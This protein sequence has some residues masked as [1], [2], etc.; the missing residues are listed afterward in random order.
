MKQWTLGALALL[1]SAS[2]QAADTLTIKAGQTHTLDA[3]RSEWVLDELVLEDKATLVVPAALG[4]IQLDAARVVIGN[5]VRIV[6]TGV[7]GSAGAAGADQEGKAANCEDGATGGHGSH[8]SAGGDGVALN[9]TLR[10]ARLDSLQID[11]R[12]GTGGVG[13]TGGKGQAAGE[14]ENC[15]PP[16][17]GDGGRGGDGGDGGNG[18]HVRVFYTLL[19]ESGLSGA[20]GERI[21]VNAEGGKAAAGGNGGTGGEGSPGRFITMKT[22]SGNKKWVAGG[23]PGAE[24]VSGKAGRDGSKG[25]I[26]VQQDLRSRMDEL[27]QQQ[28]AQV[29]AFSSEMAQR[30]ASE[31]AAVEASA[32]QG[33]QAVTAQ[34]DALKAAVGGLATQDMVQQQG[35]DLETRTAKLEQSLETIMKR[36][37]QL[38]QKL[39]QL[40]NQPKPQPAP[41]TP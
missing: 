35:S 3:S 17:G 36:L 21:K 15:N 6:A 4:Q 12:G 31:K 14:V 40:Q 32:A 5:G 7:D 2:L 22:L 26:L 33:L 30:L 13:G 41:A 20:L 29:Q 18:G 38:E 23:K 19:P 16:K 25:Q 24:G 9:L 1:A 10:I 28:A 37:D 11:T 34:L 27:I 8:G 39:N